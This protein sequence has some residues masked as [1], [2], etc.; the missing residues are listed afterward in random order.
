MIG[1][2]P[3]R[4]VPVLVLLPALMG[5][6]ARAEEGGDWLGSLGNFIKDGLGPART[7]DDI[8]KEEE[9]AREAALKAAE[10][11]KAAASARARAVHV[12]PPLPQEAEVD[13]APEVKASSIASTPDVPAPPAKAAARPSASPSLSSALAVPPP[14]SPAAQ[15]PG[16]APPQPKP[17]RVVQAPPPPE[18]LISRIAATATLDQAAR[19]GKKP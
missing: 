15:A 16:F 17:K 6:G 10:M 12:P 8:R 5:G 1:F 11:E 18:P 7:L 19:I 9:R 13:P 3:L 14:P 4:L 2:R